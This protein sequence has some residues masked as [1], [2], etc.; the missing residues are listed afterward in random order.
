MRLS[1]LQHHANE[2][3]VY[4]RLRRWGCS[5]RI[6]NTLSRAWGRIVGPV[7]YRKGRV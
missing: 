2:L 7:L 6:A 5:K 4:C 1:P 3:H